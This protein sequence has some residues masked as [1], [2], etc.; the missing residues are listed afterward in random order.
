MFLV[1][2]K[3]QAAHWAKWLALSA[4]WLVKLRQN[5]FGYFWVWK[6]RKCFAHVA[7][8]VAILQA[9]SYDSF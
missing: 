9:A 1:S 6:V 5:F 4:F 3:A 8:F 2:L 7:A